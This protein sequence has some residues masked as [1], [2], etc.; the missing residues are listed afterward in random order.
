MREIIFDCD[1]GVDDAIAFVMAINSS[2]IN[3]SCIISVHGNTNVDYTTANA[4]KLVEYFNL[5]IPVFTGSREPISVERIEAE[6]FHGKDGLGD[7]RL[8]MPVIT[9]H[10]DGVKNLAEYVSKGVDTILATGP[11]TNIA[12]AFDEYPDQMAKLKE[13]VIMGGA[14]YTPGNFI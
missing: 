10:N 5:E 9:P 7:N 1:P 4:L 13:L 6:D 14:I 3:I 8:P 12:K 2:Q 11:L